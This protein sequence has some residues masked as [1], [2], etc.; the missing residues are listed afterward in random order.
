MGLRELAKR[1]QLSAGLISKIENF[2][3]IPSLS[4]LIEIANALEVDVSHLV[5]D[6]NGE[7][8]APY[9]LVREGGGKMEKREDSKGL[10][11]QFLLAQNISNYSMR[12]N[13]VT[14][15]PNTTRKPV[16]TNALELIHVLEGQVTYGFK[17]EEVTL[18]T[19]DTLYF[20][21]K[22]AH[23]VKNTDTRPARL[24]KVYLIRQ[25]E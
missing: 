24:F 17:N 16:S 8:E 9:L 14:V 22:L 11:Y 19:G 2:R 13:I 10:S 5:R 18:S 23:S 3:T 15:K 20:D 12:V 1:S 7:A 4:V 21:G 6:L 25:T